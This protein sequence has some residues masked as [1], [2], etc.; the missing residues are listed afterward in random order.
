MNG[1][2]YEWAMRVR[3]FDLAN[4][5]REAAPAGRPLIADTIGDSTHPRDAVGRFT[6]S[7]TINFKECKA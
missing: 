5:A 6:V 7:A 3:D 1:A 2:S 4:Q